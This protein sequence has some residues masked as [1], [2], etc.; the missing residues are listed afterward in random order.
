MNNTH[1]AEAC[2][3]LFAQMWVKTPDPAT[4]PILLIIVWGC[5][6]RCGVSDF[7]TLAALMEVFTTSEHPLSFRTRIGGLS[8]PEV[9]RT[10]ASLWI[11]EVERETIHI[12]SVQ[13]PSNIH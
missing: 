8:N 7:P 10:A 2:I 12:R 3:R 11:L 13:A 4:S 9:V 6:L 1:K 5:E